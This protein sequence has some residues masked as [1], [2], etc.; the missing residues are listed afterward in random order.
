[1]APIR[2][3][4]ARMKTNYYT[5]GSII[6]SADDCL[7][8]T[9]TSEEAYALVVNATDFGVEAVKELGDSMNTLIGCAQVALYKQLNCV[10]DQL[11]VVRNQ[12]I[13]LQMQFQPYINKGNTLYYELVEELQECL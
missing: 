1:M 4:Q 9:N 11:E 10:F 8:L 5:T 3:T 7:K 12:V 2:E 6:R 13:A